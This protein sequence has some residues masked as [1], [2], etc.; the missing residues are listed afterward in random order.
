MTLN[1][2]L[3]GMVIIIVVVVVIITT[4]IIVTIIIVSDLGHQCLFRSLSFRIKSRA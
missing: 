3:A 1:G 2:A 4:I